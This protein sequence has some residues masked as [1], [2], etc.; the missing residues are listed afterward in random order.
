MEFHQTKFDHSIFILEK[1]IIVVYIDD[2]LLI[3]KNIDE[4]NNIK[5]A[6]RGNSRWQTWGYISIIL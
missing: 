3:E 4:I 5:Y 6:L 1:I 2:L